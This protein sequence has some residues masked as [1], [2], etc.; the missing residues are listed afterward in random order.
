[1]F[2]SSRPGKHLGAVVNGCFWHGLT[3]KAK[4]RAETW[5]KLKALRDKAK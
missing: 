1:M 5:I 3:P 4:V 2:D